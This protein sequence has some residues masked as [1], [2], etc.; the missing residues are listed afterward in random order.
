[1]T[2]DR[3]RRRRSHGGFTL[4]EVLAALVLMG[5][6]IPV[7]MRGATLALRSAGLARHQAEAATLGEAKLSEM[8]TQGDWL[9]GGS[10]GDFGADFPIYRW[11]LQSTTRDFDITELMLTVTWQERG[12]ERSMNISTLAYLSQSTG[13]GTGTAGGTG[14]GTGG[15]P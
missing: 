2:N 4:I 6:V 7:A 9:S 14:T 12:E 11:T 1:M 15:G 3:R 5:I 8:V 13:N 10:S